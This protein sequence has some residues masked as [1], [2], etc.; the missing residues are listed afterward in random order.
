LDNVSAAALLLHL[1]FLHRSKFLDDQQ[2]DDIV[3]LLRLKDQVD[4]TCVL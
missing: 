3:G 1:N 2:R 4:S